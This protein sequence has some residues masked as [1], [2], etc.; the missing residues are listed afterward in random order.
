MGVKA[1]RKWCARPTG[2]WDSS[3]SW[4]QCCHVLGWKF[5]NLQN[6]KIKIKK[7]RK[8]ITHWLPPT[9]Q[10]SFE[11]SPSPLLPLPNILNASWPWLDHRPR[12]SPPCQT[13]HFHHRATKKTSESLRQSQ[14]TRPERTYSAP[15]LTSAAAPKSAEG[16]SPPPD[17]RRS[18]RLAG[19]SNAIRRP[20]SHH[21]HHPAARHSPLPQTDTAA[22][23]AAAPRQH[24]PL[25]CVPAPAAPANGRPRTGF[26]GS[27]VAPA[28]V[29]N[30]TS[31]TWV[32]THDDTS[33]LRLRS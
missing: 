10:A 11:G 3:E 26:R 19:Y 25:P 24:P 5:S 1:R 6:K 4:R 32:A 23:S 33:Y 31:Q 9:R 27:P 8:N 16:P 30:H 15:H 7:Y 22:P 18:T 28:T 13:H 17:S 20:R 12:L 21:P 14:T 2:Y 29:P